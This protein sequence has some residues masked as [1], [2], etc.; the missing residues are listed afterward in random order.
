M[1]RLTG[2]SNRNQPSSKPP[3]VNSSSNKNIQ[4]APNKTSTSVPKKDN[5][6]KDILNR[7]K[8]VKAQYN[9]RSRNSAVK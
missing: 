2:A 3:I 9:T 8:E 1:D 6:A 4:R 5:N 7:M